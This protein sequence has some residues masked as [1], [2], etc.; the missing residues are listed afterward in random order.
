MLAIVDSSTDEASSPPPQGAL[1]TEESGLLAMAMQPAACL[2][3]ALVGAPEVPGYEI[4]SKLGVGASGEVWLADEIETGRIA[5]LKILHHKGATGASAEV[6]QREIR[7]LATLV[8]P[9]L[10]LLHRAVTTRDGRHGLATEWID[11]WPLDEWLEQH[12]DVPLTKKLE[13]FRGIVAGVAFL[14]DHGVIHRDL[15]PANLIVDAEGRPKIVDFGLARLHQE[16]TAT[17]SDGGSIGV[18]GTLHFMAPEQAANGPGARTMPVDVYALGLILHRLLT[19]TW[20]RPATDTPAETLALVINPP[21]LV[22][23][24]PARELPRDLLAILRQALAT[25]SSRRYRHARDLE[26]DLDRY[27][28]KQPVAARKHTLFYLTTTLLR[29]Q[30]RRSVFAACLVLA[31]LTAG[32]VIYHRH[33]LV[34]ERN[35]KNLRY[36]YT[37]TSFTLS[38]LRDEL[39]A[40]VPEEKGDRYPAGVVFPDAADVGIPL[41]PVDSNGELDL[42]YYHAQLADLRA[43]ISEGHAQQR[44]ALTAIQAALDLYSQLAREAPDDPQRLMDA[45]RAR[46]S[47]ALLLEQTGQT[48]AAGT[49]ACKVLAQLDRLAT[50]PDFD[51]THLIPIRC[52]ALWLAAK[53]AHRVGDPAKAVG[54]AREMLATARSMPSGLLVRPENE[55]A[56]RIALAALDLVT[57][58]LDA[59]ATLLAGVE[60]DIN[61]ATQ[62]CRAAYEHEPEIPA[63]ARGL[64]YCLLAQARMTLRTGSGGELRPLFEEAERI[65]IG[66]G[67][68]VRLSS[69]PLIK[70]FAAITNAWTGSVLDHPDPSVPGA[71]AEIAYRFI[72]YLRENGAADDA[73]VIE[74]ARLYVNESRLASRFNDLEKAA[75]AS[76]GA[77]RILGSRQQKDP[78]RISLALL[79][80]VALH[81]ARTL[82]VYPNSIWRENHHGPYLERL[83]KQLSD[84]STELIPEQQRELEALRS[85]PLVDR[86]NHGISH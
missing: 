36:A 77:V 43:A 9:N 60:N 18:S 42:R 38:Q 20:L 41:L 69:F 1:T 61:H 79:T 19:G 39:R 51:P 75:R 55:I 63:L 53:D 25:D 32:G 82:A 83:L 40:A 84:R 86:Q 10:V 12:P 30:A 4:I 81:Q 54:L 34:V 11:G 46:I 71:A 85:A 72:R 52:D 47:F 35:E 68:R 6:M 48:V 66:P 78:D 45:A 64:G 73:T 56:P 22:F 37:L 7:M 65:L 21:P 50:W 2:M 27:A 3:P 49:E 70:D 5:A 62:A 13:I 8:H 59:D 15:K 16:A 57:Y 76:T 14:H 28:A 44:S 67:S 17:G 24:G 33:R 80:A 31:A 74:R 58:A 23:H 29:R 26:A